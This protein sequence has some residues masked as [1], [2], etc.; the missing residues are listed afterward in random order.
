MQVQMTRFIIAIMAATTLAGVAHAAE[1][2]DPAYQGGDVTTCR[3]L[4]ITNGV[5]IG[6]ESNVTP[7]SYDGTMIY[8]RDR[9]DDRRKDDDR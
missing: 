6:S 8:R 3:G 5:C 1:R 7:D 2:L 9:D 4:L